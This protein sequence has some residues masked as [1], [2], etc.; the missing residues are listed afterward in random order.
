MAPH[1]MERCLLK[2]KFLAFPI[3]EPLG[4]PVLVYRF[5]GGLNIN[6]SH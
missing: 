4:Q 3:I 1:F 2:G 6:L 5:V